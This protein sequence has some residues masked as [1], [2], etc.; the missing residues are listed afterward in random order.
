MYQWYLTTDK[1]SKMYTGASNV[2]WKCKYGKG[3]FYHLYWTCDRTKKYWDQ[4]HV[5]IQKILKNNIKIKPNTFLLGLMDKEKKS[6]TLL[7]C[8]LIAARMLYVQK[9]KD[10]LIATMEE[11]LE[12]LMELAEIHC[13]NQRK[14]HV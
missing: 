10:T 4:I 5:L 3:T 11:W 7:L 9:W 13:F 6:R 12:K 2:Y 1:L 14:E 8:I